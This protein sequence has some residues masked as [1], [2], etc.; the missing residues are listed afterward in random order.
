MMTVFVAKQIV[1][2]TSGH[3]RVIEEPNLGHYC[4]RF[5]I[6]LLSFIRNLCLSWYFVQISSQKKK[7]GVIAPKRFV[8]RVKKQNEYFRS[9]MHQKLSLRPL[10][11]RRGG[12]DISSVASDDG[13]WRRI[14][15]VEGELRQV[16]RFSI[17]FSL[18]FLL[19][20]L[21]PPGSGGNGA[22]TAPID[23][24]PPK[25]A[26]TDAHE[27]LNFLLNELAD[28]LQKESDAAKD[29]IE[30]SSP[31][32]KLANGP[33]H[34]LPNG[35]P[36]EPLLTWV[37]KNF[38]SYVSLCSLQE[39]Q[40]RMKIKK[41]PHILVIHLKRF[42]YVEQ[43]GRYKKLSYRVVFPMELK[44]NNTVEDIDSEYSL[45][46]VVVHVGS[47]PNH[48]HYVSLVKSHNHWLLFDDENVEM[49]DES[50][51]QT[52]F[53]SSQEYSG[54]TDNGYILFY[55]SLGGKS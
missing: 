32:E 14:R 43:L 35:V 51:V 42:K 15:I 54:N 2:A 19:P 33:N 25:R 52:F 49:I 6:Y 29:S 17:F 31:S 4:F 45:F 26:T 18:F 36:K 44:L 22:E 12:D 5:I 20:R 16:S 47:G 8:Q 27:F 40:K 24:T 23:G 11:L 21:I 13:G 10:C 50:M 55:E 1:L 7:T 9:Y 48:G 41:P 28:I 46:A 39:A 53:G 3:I 30:T 37:H 38:Q 34:S